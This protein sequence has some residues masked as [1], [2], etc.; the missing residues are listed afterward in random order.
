MSSW[1][2]RKARLVFGALLRIGWKL[3][4]QSG[5]QKWGRFADIDVAGN[6]HLPIAEVS[7]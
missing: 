5:G 7:Y 1:G 2:A 4:R 6:R 3:K